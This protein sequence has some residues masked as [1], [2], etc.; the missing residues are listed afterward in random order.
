MID[1]L[2]L[3]VV[4]C[5]TQL[6]SPSAPD[7]NTTLTEVLDL[8]STGGFAGYFGVTDDG[9]VECHSCGTISPPSSVKMHSLRRLEGASDPDDMLA[10]AAISCPECNTRG[11]LTMMFGPMASIGDVTVLSGLHDSRDD[12]LAPPNSAPDEMTGDEPAEGR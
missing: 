10:V 2:V 3:W 12:D 1:Q 6:H 4:K 7:D 11:T 9:L 5:M 8:Y